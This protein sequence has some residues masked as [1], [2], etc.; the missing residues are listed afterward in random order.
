MCLPNPD[1]EPLGAAVEKSGD[2]EKMNAK[3]ASSSALLP[4]WRRGGMHVNSA[5]SG[6]NTYL[7]VLLLASHLPDEV[8]RAFAT[9][10]LAGYAA[11]AAVGS[12]TVYCILVIPTYMTSLLLCLWSEG[13][14]RYNP[15]T[16][17]IAAS[18]AL[19]IVKVN[20]CM[21]V[22]LHRYAAHAAFK[23]GPIA[24]AAVAVLGCLANQGGPIWWAS[25]HRC[26]HKY[27][28]T[29]RDP[30]SPSICGTEAAFSFFE[31]HQAVEEEFAPRHLESA[32]MRLL[33]TWAWI[34]VFV[35]LVLAH[36]LLGR[37]GLFVAYSSA[38][39]SQA[40]TLWFNIA[41][42]PPQ[43]DTGKKCKAT[44]GK[45]PLYSYYL[46]FHVL[47]SLYL[48]FGVFVAEGEHKHHHDYPG[49]A[50]RKPGDLAYWTFLAPLEKLGLVWDVNK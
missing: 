45:E 16:G 13:Q 21:S 20:I 24:K 5:G 44:D 11:A 37:D 1:N 17:L 33:D 34:P 2:A 43:M 36:A 6:I 10:L 26:H 40:I 41:N 25:Q 14:Y 4:W 9:L 19:A 23:C 47:D 38:W 39:I 3:K 7:P 28:D 30:H 22:C 31:K 29:P 18:V 27:C 8:R 35:E 12:R 46:P 49:L 48:L 32:W 42:H 50:K 15:A